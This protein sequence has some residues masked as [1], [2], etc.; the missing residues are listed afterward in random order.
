MNQSSKDNLQNMHNTKGYGFDTQDFHRGLDYE[1]QNMQGR[2]YSSMLSNKKSEHYDQVQATDDQLGSLHDFKTKLLDLITSGNALGVHRLLKL[3]PENDFSK[4]RFKMM[5]HDGEEIYVSV[6][7]LAVNVGD[8]GML[9]SLLSYLNNINIDEGI[10]AKP[11][12]QHE[13]QP[14]KIR[15]TTPLQFACNLGLY[16]IV[17][18]LLKEGANPNGHIPTAY[19]SMKYN[20]ADGQSPL[21]IVLQKMYHTKSDDVGLGF[22]RN[23]DEKRDVDY[24]S[25]LRLLLQNK[26]DLNLPSINGTLP[27]FKALKSSYQTLQTFLEFVPEKTKAINV[28]NNKG[29]SPLCKVAFEPETEENFKKLTLLLKNQATC[30]KSL[31]DYHPMYLALKAKNVRIVR[32]LF[33]HSDAIHCLANYD[34][35]D[36]FLLALAKCNNDQVF[37]ECMCEWTKWVKKKEPQNLK[38]LDITQ[39]NKDNL[40]ILHIIAMN[41]SVNQFK[42]LLNNCN[43]LNTVCSYT[44]EDIFSLLN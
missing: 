7:A 6:I 3:T 32:A 8:Y 13:G 19:Q 2:N 4:F 42:S 11:R 37:D 22:K 40:N 10:E 43:H 25:C 12:H 28:L 1:D 27:V 5:N 39:R 15:R 33:K 36:P 23:F 21:I 16:K 29:M 31:P 35:D 20:F 38:Y 30:A 24:H 9:D 18:R 14:I 26:A 41:S 34:A 44:A 17:D